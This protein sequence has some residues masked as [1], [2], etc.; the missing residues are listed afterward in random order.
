MKKFS[1][2]LLTLACGSA[3]IACNEVQARYIDLTSGEKIKVVKD[4]QGRLV[5]AE[6]KKPI[7]FYV[8]TK[9]KDT[10]D[11]RTGK[12][13]NG[14]LVKSDD[15]GYEYISVR[16]ALASD[17]EFKKKVEKDG[18]VKIKSGNKKIKIDGETGEKK[19]KYDN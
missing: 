19:V 14:E 1:L 16:E 3:W 9:T 11:G 7:R 12:V 18:D 15:G 4:K 8:D 2:I 10:L 13:V 17:D 6:D 5:N